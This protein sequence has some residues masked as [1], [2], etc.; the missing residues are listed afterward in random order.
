MSNPTIAYYNKNAVD[1]Y[2]STIH[3]DMSVHYLK[4]LGLL[5]PTAYIL[6]LG[7]GSGR[8]SKYFFDKGYTV[9]AV[10]G[11]LELCKIASNYLGKPVRHLLFDELDYVEIF[12]AIW[13]SASLLHI[14]KNEL[15]NI[16]VKISRALKMDGFL[17]AA[18]KYGDFCGER[19]GRIFT[20]LTEQAL[21]EIIK[22]IEC[23]TIIE[24][25]VT[26]DV[27]QEHSD[28]KWLNAII[29]KQD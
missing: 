6:D 13:A 17:Y 11:S 16:L 14:P 24:T 10:D 15:P 9:E 28:E 27:R 7:C 3:A 26:F 1:F 25:A 19:N 4:F 12:D 8:D 22:H 21:S 23:F 18:F 5:T 2:A 29:Q 20:D